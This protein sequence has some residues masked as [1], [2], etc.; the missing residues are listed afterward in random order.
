MKIPCPISNVE[1]YV[2]DN[3]STAKHVN[4][5]Q[6]TLCIIKFSGVLQ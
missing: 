2:Y 3:H 6:F 1:I 4:D 5:T